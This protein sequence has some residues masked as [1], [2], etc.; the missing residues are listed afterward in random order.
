MKKFLIIGSLIFFG[1]IIGG[2]LGP[3]FVGFALVG[4]I[5]FIMYKFIAAVLYALIKTYKNPANREL[6]SEDFKGIGSAIFNFIR[7]FPYFIKYH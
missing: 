6:K 7:H 3:A 2:D 4:L 1:I 5:F